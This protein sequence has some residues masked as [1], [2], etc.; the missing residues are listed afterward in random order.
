MGSWEGK[1][2]NHGLRAWRDWHGLLTW[3]DSRAETAAGTSAGAEILTTRYGQ[4]PHN[5]LRFTVRSSRRLSQCIFQKNPCSAGRGRRKRAILNTAEHAVLLNKLYPQVK[6][7]NQSFT[8]WSLV[9]AQLNKRIYPMP[10]SSSHL[11]PTKDGGRRKKTEK[12]LWSQQFRGTGSLKEG[13][14]IVGL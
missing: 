2:G 11:V 1:R 10:V 14:L 5:I 8:C 4:G 13:D 9:R 7:F 6:L 3:G 12:H